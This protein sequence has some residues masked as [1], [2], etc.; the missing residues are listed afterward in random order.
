MTRAFDPAHAKAH[1][2]TNED[3]DAVDSPELSGDELATAL[4]IQQAAPELAAALKSEIARRGRP[5][6]DNPK[7]A[8]SMRLDRD[9]VDRLK[10]GGRGW[11][12]RANA[13]LREKMGL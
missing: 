1:G 13:I 4:P 7:V 2:Y 6:V 9:L 12:T 11:Q 5:P 10:E 8:V 3:W